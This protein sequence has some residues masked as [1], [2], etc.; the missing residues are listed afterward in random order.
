[1]GYISID[2]EKTIEHEIREYCP[3]CQKPYKIKIS[4]I[5]KEN[6]LSSSLIKPHEKCNAFLI[7]LDTHGTF[8]GYQTI[9]SNLLGD[10]ANPEELDKYQN[11]FTLIEDSA[12]FYQILQLSSEIGAKAGI[13]TCKNHEEN[14]F[15]KSKLYNEWL[16]NFKRDKEPFR[17]LY[18]NNTIIGTLNINEQMILTIGFGLENFDSNLGFNDIV[19]VLSHLREKSEAMA[20]KILSQNFCQ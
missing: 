4:I 3:Y 7:Y 1:M 5:N 14:E 16:E 19:G 6:G 8:R 13:F 17:F 9:N 18:L 20:E 2:S 10:P 15:L 12:Q 11:I